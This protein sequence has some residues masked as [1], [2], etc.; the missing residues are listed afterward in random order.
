MLPLRDF[1]A[2]FPE[3]EIFDKFGPE[4]VLNGSSD[5]AVIEI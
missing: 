3:V 1:Q 5:T 2:A 4:T